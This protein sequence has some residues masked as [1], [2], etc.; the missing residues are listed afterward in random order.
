MLVFMDR[1]IIRLRNKCE[2]FLAELNDERGA[3][4]FVSVLL[5]ILIAVAVAFVFREQLLGLVESV[6]N[7]IDIEGLSTPPAQ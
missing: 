2:N 1:Q 3:S 7:A 6:F 5:I 4:D